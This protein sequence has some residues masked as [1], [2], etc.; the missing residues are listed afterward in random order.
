M[1][2]FS[3]TTMSSRGQVVI[4]DEIRK[5]LNLQTG[6]Q[7]MIFCDKDIVM[8]KVIAPPTMD[9]FSD[10]LKKIRTAAKKAGARQSDVKAA[11]KEARKK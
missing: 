7:F 6:A 2:Q 11:I 9:G 4:P 1:K 10:M 3:S 5:S 8:L